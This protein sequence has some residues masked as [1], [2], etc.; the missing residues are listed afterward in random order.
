MVPVQSTCLRN[1]STT[2]DLAW[3][4]DNETV[5]QP[6]FLGEAV[7]ACAPRPRRCEQVPVPVPTRRSTAA[8]PG[9]A[10]GRFGVFALAIQLVIRIRAIAYVRLEDVGW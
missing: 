4:I 5:S 6:Q 10:T 7:S 9:V 2:V 3:A 8:C 1:G